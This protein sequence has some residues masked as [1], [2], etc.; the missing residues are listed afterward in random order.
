MRGTIASRPSWSPWAPAVL[1]GMLGLA[2]GPALGQT[3]SSTVSDPVQRLQEL[4][5]RIDALQGAIAN[6]G[7]RVELLKD[8]AL[9]GEVGRTHAVIVHRNRLGPAFRLVTVR[10]ELDG[11]LLFERDASS[12]ELD[13]VKTVPLYAGAMRPGVHQVAVRATVESGTFG[14]F[15]YAEGYRFE[16][17]SRYALQVREGRVN[18]LEVVFF[19]KPDITLSP[20]ER[21]AVR[22]DLAVEAGLPVER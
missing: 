14:V 15:S 18:R 3:G 21:L 12:T 8:S 11:E 19:Q 6:V 20:E 5:A 4:N 9:T 7:A 17:R 10:Y 1:W 13:R 2:A 16:V 22:Y